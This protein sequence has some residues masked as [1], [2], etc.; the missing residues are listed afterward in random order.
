M[1]IVV[2]D[3]YTLN[4]GDLSWGDL[5]ALGSCTVYDRT[6]SN[7]ILERSANAPILLTNK[8]PLTAQT[9][10]S[11][12]DLAY[13]GVLATGYNIVDV[14]AAAKRNIPVTNVPT[15]GTASVAQFAFALLLELCHRVQSHSDAVHAGEW[16]QC[17]DFCFWKTPLVEL[18][19]QTMGIVGFGRI[20]KQVA[21]IASAFGMNV[22]VA[23]KV[24]S[25]PPAG[26]DVEWADIPDLLKH[27]D[28]VSLH[29]PL[30]PDTQGLIN[31]DALA[32]MKSSACLI[33]TSRGP[34]IVEQDLADALN[35]GQIAGA[36]V[37]VLADEPPTANNPL[38]SAKNCLATPHIAWATK[39]AR[40]RLMATAVNNVR[41]FLAGTPTNVVN[42]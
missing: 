23:D 25:D 7:L 36:A 21:V 30:F 3:G 26:I 1:K 34:L 5:E 2:L 28:V 35:T 9:I 22:I 8:T 39:Q 14:D 20:G 19:G 24:K 13:I 32:M 27:A 17:N 10:G 6:P 31:R 29:C 16:T 41:T 37:D 11:L 15:Y 40:S 4:P 42:L 12:P 38:L 33:N 18:A